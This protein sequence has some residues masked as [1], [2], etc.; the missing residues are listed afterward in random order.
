LRRAPRRRRP[1]LTRDRPA[2]LDGRD[3][4]TMTPALERLAEMVRKAET[5]SRA[6][7]LGAEVQKAAE[8][9]QAAEARARAIE[10]RLRDD[11]PAREKQLEDLATD[12]VRL[13]ELVRKVASIIAAVGPE[14]GRVFEAEI[15]SPTAQID[16][17]RAE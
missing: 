6:Q 9:F 8:R 17:R 11:R 5:Q 15:A 7:K 10:Q 1:G 12:E 2:D 16:S 3:P 14:Q 4:R 13:K